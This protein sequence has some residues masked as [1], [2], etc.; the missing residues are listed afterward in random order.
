MKSSEAWL[1]SEGLWW[2]LWVAM[3]AVAAAKAL[4]P[5]PIFSGGADFALSVLLASLAALQIS[6]PVRFLTQHQ[7][8]L[9]VALLVLFCVTQLLQFMVSLVP[10]S[11]VRS[12]DFSA[13]YIAAKVLSEKPPQ[14]IYQLPL[15]ADGR[16]NLNVETPLSSPWH[17]AAVRYHVPFSAPYIYPPFVAVAM[18]PL[19]RLPFHAAYLAWSFLSI[20]LVGA[21]VL[22]TLRVAGVPLE[23]KLAL[24]LAVGLFSYNPFL[25]NLFFGQIGGVILFLLAASVWLLS[26]QRTAASALCFA[27]AT[28]I[29]LTPALAL[30]ILVFHRR[31]KWLAAYSVSLGLLLAIS[32]YA[33]GWSAHLQFWRQVLPTIS[34]GA[35][36]GQNLS[37]V[38]LIQELFLGYV[39]LAPHQ[40]AHIP[41]HADAASQLLPLVMYA[42]MLACLYVRRIENDLV[43][44]LIIITLFGLA[45]S[46][47]SWAHHY[48][49]ALLPFLYFWPKM[50]G[51]G[52]IALVALFFLVGSNLLPV[53][54][55]PLS[56]PVFQ[57]ILAA[58]IPSL[59]IALAFLALAQ[60][61]YSLSQT[62]SE[63][64][65]K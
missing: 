47:I 30:P 8:L 13:Y 22:L 59:T 35:P 27:V 45:I 49:V 63:G 21:A 48:T 62:T 17:A 11:R 41:A 54:R 65:V 4:L 60:R 24:I 46:P 1:P 9:A 7:R 50:S 19:A 42:I 31:W 15:L 44:D 58:T 33:A 3:L 39:P 18:Q 40:P 36:V 2:M 20:L 43:R 16:M 53:L 61:P 52:F 57:L 29:K 34:T 51:K 10:P 23:R 38:A 14:S 26:I 25:D 64:G 55:F 5:H 37:L 12:I 32:I 28:I 6:R 56:N